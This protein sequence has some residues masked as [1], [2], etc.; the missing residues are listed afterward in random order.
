MHLQQ[1]RVFI[2]PIRWATGIITKQSIAHVHGLPTGASCLLPHPPLLLPTSPTHTC[3]RPLLPPAHPPCPCHTPHA[4]R[5]V[6]PNHSTLPP[7]S[8]IP[9][10]HQFV[11]VTPI[12]ARHVAP[13]P[14]DASGHSLVWSHSLGRYHV[15]R[16]AVV[17]E[18]PEEFAAAVLHVYRNRTL[19]EIISQNGARFARSGG[20][21]QGVCP[22]NLREDWHAFW[23]KL[24]AASCSRMMDSN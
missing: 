5:L 3:L 1:A 17:A 21:G 22:S 7:P 23:R 10:P 4:D 12:A 20:M 19:W 11:V 13:A 15:A 24:D 8:P 2:A 9:R 6:F 16:V 18:L 14:L